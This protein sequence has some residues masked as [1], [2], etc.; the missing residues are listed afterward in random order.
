MKHESYFISNWQYYRQLEVVRVPSNSW[1]NQQAPRDQVATT[2]WILM[3]T[4]H[5][6]KDKPVENNNSFDTINS[7]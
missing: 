7:K 6:E 4:P 2:I 3:R 5:T 1:E